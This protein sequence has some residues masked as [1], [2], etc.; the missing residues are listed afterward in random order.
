[1]FR[2][3]RDGV[4]I[5]DVIARHGETLPGEA[6]LR[7]VMLSGRRVESETFELSRIRAY[8]QEAL[9]A[10]PV[11]LRALQPS[12]THFDVAIS[13]ELADYER[14]TREALISHA[15]SG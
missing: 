11:K 9:A 10:L 5:R 12:E 2:E 8:A 7:L 13:R 15:L 6:L 3:F 1:V 14:E 4:A